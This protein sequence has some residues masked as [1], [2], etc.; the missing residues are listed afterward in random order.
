MSGNILAKSIEIRIVYSPI[1]SYYFY[2]RI[3]NGVDVVTCRSITPDRAK[4]IYEANKDAAYQKPE[5]K[6]E[7]ERGP[8]PWAWSAWVIEEVE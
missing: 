2:N 4:E 6:P 8:Q 5:G 7:F 1:G 3:E